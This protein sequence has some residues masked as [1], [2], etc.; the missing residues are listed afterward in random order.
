MT[1]VGGGTRGNVSMSIWTGIDRS[2]SR[3]MRAPRRP[4]LP[5]GGAALRRGLTPLTAGSGGRE[6]WPYQLYCPAALGLGSF[7]SGARGT[8]RYG[9]LTQDVSFGGSFH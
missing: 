8:R 7:A 3:L 9:A 5:G 2:T 1:S 4:R 6:P